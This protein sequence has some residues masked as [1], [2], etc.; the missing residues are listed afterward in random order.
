MY[1]FLNID[2]H[3]NRSGLT[4]VPIE[5]RILRVI[6]EIRNLPRNALRM[7]GFRRNVVEVALFLARKLAMGFPSGFGQQKRKVF[8]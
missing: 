3:R 7:L 2:Q 5:L 4:L 6:A 1:E 8:T